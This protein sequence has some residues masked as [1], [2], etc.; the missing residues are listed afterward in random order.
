MKID[1]IIGFRNEFNSIQALREAFITHETL[2]FDGV[3]V[4]EVAHDPF[5]P[6][7][8]GAEATEKLELRTGIA[9]AFARTPTLLAHSGH[10]LNSYTKGRFVLGIGSQIKPHVERRF[11]MPWHAPAA[12]MRE[13]I[14]C[15][16]AIWDNWYEQTPLRFEGKYYRLTLMTPEFCPANTEFGRPR[17][18]LAAVGPKMTEV[19]AQEAEGV[20]LH[21]FNTQKYLEE[22]ILPRI[23]SALQ[24]VGKQR[25]DFEISFPAFVVSGDNE[26]SFEHNKAMIKYRIG[27][28]G[29]T[30]AYKPVLDCHGWGELQPELNRLSKEGKWAQ[31][32]DLISDEILQA[33]AV[34][35]EPDS[36]AKQLKARYGKLVDRISLDATTPAEVLRQQMA[37]I[38][39]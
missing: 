15:L 34:V 7:M 6:L 27:F 16:H 8:M 12:Q 39:G 28:Y 38:R 10:D 1:G 4:S 19:A 13:Y 23:D 20:I 9:V 18:A 5:L 26:E 32:P 14:R 24:S 3:M 25:Q 2:G 37:V 33:F 22:V 35:G 31:M 36:I 17:I 29:S 30:P 11:G 21:A